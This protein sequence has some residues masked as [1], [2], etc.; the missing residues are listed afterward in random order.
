VGPNG[1]GKSNLSD[2]ISWVLGEQSARSLRGARMEDV[3]FAGTKAR[4][5]VGM[6]SVT[7]VLVDPI[8][9]A[10]PP[11]PAVEIVEG[12]APKVHEIA[13]TSGKPGEVTITRRLFRS[14]ESEYLIDGRQARLRDIQ[15]IFM[16][17]GL[18]PESYAI[19]E[20]GRIGQILSSKPQDRRSVI[21]EAAGITKYK[22]RR[23]LA[24]A[25]LESS[26]QN[27]ARVFDILEEVT[28]QVNSLKRQAA[29]AKRYQELKG[30]LESQLRT[31]LAGRYV[32]LKAETEK[33]A[34]ALET[35][36]AELKDLTVQTAD[37]DAAR[38]KAQEVFYAL[39]AQ[40]TDARTSLAAM[41]LE[42]ERTKGR[43]EAQ[44]REA[45]DIEQRMTRADQESSDLEGRIGHN[46][47]ERSALA[48]SVAELEHEM[49]EVRTG[50][51]EKNQARDAIQNRV[52]EAEKTIEASRSMIL[53]LLGEASTIR[54]QIAQADTYLAGIER[55]RARV[56]KEEEVGASEIDRLAVVKEQLSARIAQRQLEMQ[57]VV[58]NRH[59]TEE[60][61]SAKR[62]AMSE[63]RQ[64]IDQLR[65]EC[66]RLRA[67]R[68]S[69][70]NI[71]SHHSYTTESTKKLLAALEGGR[72]G[73]F[74]P[75]GVLADFIEVDPAWERAAEEFLHDELE[76]VV[77]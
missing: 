42:A 17:S 62:A 55:E 2:A 59:Q 68:E 37:N 21:E 24:E 50:L 38:Q 70:E 33:A 12:E 66:S 36:S 31:V 57:S 54:N 40:L 15:D 8:A 39:E 77:V 43:L 65:A 56:Q 16:G 74:R 67:K 28:R 73:Q 34:A 30:E 63:L 11:A 26:K 6:A 72:A 49:Q 53:R 14:G 32:S 19:I 45:A 22:S 20:Q 35:A 29:K 1:C 60:G 69:V 3:I 27:L 48:Q 23:R 9:Q 4:K 58:T 41:N 64:Q 71:L 76:Y 5:P 44:V 61:L 51:L 47:T 7:M 46:E 18:G 13:P 25:K 52:R 75:E 10:A